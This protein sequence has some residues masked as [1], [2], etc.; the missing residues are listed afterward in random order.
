MTGSIGPE[1][2]GYK[3]GFF[4]NNLFDKYYRTT[5]STN[6]LGA[7][8]GAAPPRTYGVNLTLSY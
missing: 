8:D 7:Y 5:A 2:G 3:I 4:I 6:T 1:N